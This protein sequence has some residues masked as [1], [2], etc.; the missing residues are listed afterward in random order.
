MAKEHLDAYITKIYLQPSPLEVRICKYFP[1]TLKEVTQVRFN[2]FSLRSIKC[3]DDI[4]ASFRSHFIRSQRT[5]KSNIELI[6]LSQRDKEN[7]S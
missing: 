4:S 1:T 6:K 2:K 3:W 5:T 7:P